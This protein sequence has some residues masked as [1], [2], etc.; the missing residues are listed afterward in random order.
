MARQARK[1][2]ETG[3]YHVMMRGVNHLQIFEAEEDYYHFLSA[4]QFAKEQYSP[5]GT[6][7]P[8][9][10][11]Y[12]AYALMGNHV[13]VLLQVKE[14][15]IGEIVKKIASSYVFY[16]NRKYGRDGHLFKERFRSEPCDDMSYFL[17]LLRY[18]HQNPV[19]AGLAR[20]VGDYQY[21]S[22]HEYMNDYEVV[23][24]LCSTRI[25]LNRIP[26]NELKALVEDPLNEEIYCLDHEDRPKR[27]VS[28]DWI[29]NALNTYLNEKNCS[30]IQHLGKLERNEILVQLIRAG[31]SIRQ[32]G[33]LT[34]LGRGV[35]ERL[36]R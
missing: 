21:T 12:Y 22:W 36:R 34:G 18:I 5:D 7:L 28:D 8:D 35:I 11:T 31:G 26:L 30:D 27:F 17:T 14:A 25:V 13:H 19:K 33:R 1:A 16:F 10:C 9:L 15:A 29:Q 32:L 4:M 24:P 6:R 2:S 23:F 3:V 20:D